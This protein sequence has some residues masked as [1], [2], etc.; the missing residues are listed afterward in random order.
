MPAETAEEMYRDPDHCLTTTAF[1]P[2]VEGRAV[3]GG[4]RLTGRR[5]FASGIH[6]ARWLCLTATVSDGDQPRLVD[7]R[8]EMIFAIMPAASAEIVD[9]WYGLGLRGSDSNDVSVRDLFVPTAWTCPLVPPFEA[10]R[11]YRAPLYRLPAVAAIVLATFPSIAIA[12]ARNAIEEARAVCARKVPM[13]SAVPLRDRG[14]AQAALGRAE[15][16]LRSARALMHETMAEAWE[17]TL[18]GEPHTLPQ[19]AD[20]LLSAAHA[21]QVSAEVTDA[22]FTLGGSAAVFVGQRLERLFRDARVI[23]Q[24]GFVNAQRYETAAQVALGLE[25]DL[26]FVHF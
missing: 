3:A 14:V 23:R 13:G 19:K 9:T 7:G 25:P 4:Y 21:A 6:A 18:A 8:P 1:Q 15:A 10:N 22:M 17:R 16:M 24:H 2:P 12:V 20:L 11:H 5:P 26:P